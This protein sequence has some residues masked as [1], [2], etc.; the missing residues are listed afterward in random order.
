MEEAT[1][2]TIDID[3]ILD[4]RSRELFG[5]QLRWCDLVRT[6]KLS[7]AKTYSICEY[8]ESAPQPLT[9]HT[10]PGLANIE[11]EPNSKFYLRPIPSS[12]IDAL[13]MDEAAKKAYQNPGY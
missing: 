11:N 13:D 3:Y 9:L 7:R 6:K 10:R 4:E 5:E 2:R 12:F 8:N 1:P